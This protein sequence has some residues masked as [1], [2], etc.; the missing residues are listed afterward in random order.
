MLLFCEKDKRGGIC[1]VMGPRRVKANNKYLCNYNPNIQS[2]FLAYLDAVNL[3]GKAMSQYLPYRG[4]EW[5]GDDKINS[6]NINRKKAAKKIMNTPVD[7][8][9]G[10]FIQVDLHY[11]RYIKEH[12]KSFPLAHVTRSV[13]YEELSDYQ[14]FQIKDQKYEAQEKLICDQYDKIG[15]VCHYRNL[16]FYLR[17][18]MVITKIHKVLQFKQSNWLQSYIDF[19]TA[20]RNEFK[21]YPTEK[22]F[23]KLMNNSFYGKTVEN[24]RN[25]QEICTSN[26]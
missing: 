7:N 8:D 25:R 6:Y 2:N 15:Y 10:Y 17:Q 3:Y 22:A 1:G 23:F 20:K 24:I 19:N 21:D 16:K 11:P 12:T 4:F 5:W 26:K 13:K 18:G 14:Q 9:T